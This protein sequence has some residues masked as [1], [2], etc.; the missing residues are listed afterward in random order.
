M[1]REPLLVS[2]QKAEREPSGLAQ[3]LVHRCLPADRDP[4]ERRLE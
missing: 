1:L 3:K 4:D 2:G